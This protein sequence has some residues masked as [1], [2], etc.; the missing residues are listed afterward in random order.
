MPCR[1]P[2]VPSSSVRSPRVPRS[3]PSS[4]SRH[5]WRRRHDR[6]PTDPRSS[7]TWRASEHPTSGRWLPGRGRDD[8]DPR[9]RGRCEH[10][11]LAAQW[12]GGA[13]GWFDPYG[14]HATPTDL[15]GHGTQTAGIAVGRSAGGTA[16]GVAPNANGSRPASSTMR[17]PGPRR[18]STSHSSGS[19]IPTATLS[20]NDVPRVVN[21]SWTFGTPGC[22]L[23]FEPDLAALVAANVTPVFA[24]G[25]FGPAAG[26]APS[27]ANNPD[28]F[29]VGSIDAST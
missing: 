3:R 29:A 27:P 16:I 4:R 25:N 24:A 28:A 7:R 18:P 15:N 10:P 17:G 9:Y 22:D 19:S 13:G 12:R 21:N 2:V 26:S 14:Q 20:T 23:A 1:S 5:S 6:R 11:D 8:R